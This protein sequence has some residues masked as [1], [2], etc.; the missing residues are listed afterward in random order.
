MHRPNGLLFLPYLELN[1]D[2]VYLIEKK[3]AGIK[4]GNIG[5]CYLI[6]SILCI[7]FNDLPIVNNFFPKCKE[8]TK[9]SDIIRMLIYENRNKERKLF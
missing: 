7:I 2:L 1:Y 6:S 5:D 3:K 4:Q 8:Y 9:Y